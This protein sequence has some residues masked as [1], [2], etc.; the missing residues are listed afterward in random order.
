MKYLI[1][2]KLS[3]ITLVITLISSAQETMHVGNWTGSD[4]QGKPVSIILDNKSF[5]TFVENGNSVGGESFD[6][7]GQDCRYKYEINYLKN[8]IEIDFVVSDNKSNVEKYRIKS[9]IRFI[10]NNTI[11]IKNPK[12]S[13]RP[14]KF[15]NKS[16]G[17]VM[18][19]KRII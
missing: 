14:K 16:K 17:D 3:L 6:V 18:R 8:P 13:D 11:E 10:D 9:I 5:V 12:K 4:N 19:F 1:I 2:L 7:K 15:G